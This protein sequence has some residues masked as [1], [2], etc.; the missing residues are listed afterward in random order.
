MN[1]WVCSDRR[2][3]ATGETDRLELPELPLDILAQQVVAASAA[4]EWTE[5]ALLH[6]IRRAYPIASDARVFDSVIRMLP[7]LLTKRGKRS[8][9]ATTP[10]TSRIRGRRNAQFQQ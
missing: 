1:W 10:L 9:P 6:M 3:S 4:E 5:D 2:F 7:R 8:A